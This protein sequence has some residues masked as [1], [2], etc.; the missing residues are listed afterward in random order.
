LIDEIGFGG[1]NKSQLLTKYNLRL[2]IMWRILVTLSALISVS[3]SQSSERL[4]LLTD[5]LLQ[6]FM[7][8]L[9]NNQ[10]IDELAFG[11][12]QN[13]NPIRVA[14]SPDYE[15]HPFRF[16]TRDDI[17]LP[18]E[19]SPRKEYLEHSSLWGHQY[20]Q[21]GAGEGSQRLKPDGSVRNV[22]VI[23]TDAVLPAYCNPPN[24]CPIGYTA[25]DGCLEEFENTAAFSRDYQS[26]QECM[27]DTEHMFDCPGNTDENELETLARSIQNEGLMD[28]TLDK[29]VDK[30]G[31][32][33]SEHKVVAK[34]FFTKQTHN[35]YFKQVSKKAKAVGSKAKPI[36]SYPFL[37]GEKLPVVAK[38]AP[39]LAK[40]I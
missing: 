16:Q 36:N 38:K 29:L 25:E 31:G 3:R 28:S 32:D 39:H 21:G 13:Q 5:S 33:S 7:S 6:Q 19:P 24:P 14:K 1:L 22:Q 15:I 12:A 18:R 27:C 30:I 34:K 17:L 40:G 2:S 10:N 9:D 26:S 8:R 23:K 20:M 37:S 35:K 4:N 11:S